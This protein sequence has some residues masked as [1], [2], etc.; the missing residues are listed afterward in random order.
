LSARV[1]SRLENVTYVNVEI[2]STI[3]NSDGVDITVTAISSGLFESVGTL[4]SVKI[5]A[6]I[7]EIGRR[8]FSW[9]WNLES[10]VFEEDS[11]LQVIRSDAF[12]GN[13][14]RNILIPAS[15]IRIEQ[16]AFSNMWELRSVEFE[17]GSQLSTLRSFSFA[18]NYNLESFT[19]PE[20][21]SRIE[22]G[23]LSGNRNIKEIKVA[24]GNA[25]YASLDG[26]LYNTNFTSLI[27]YPGGITQTGFTMPNS[28]T[29]IEQSAFRGAYNLQSIQFTTESALTFIGWDALSDTGLRNISLPSGLTRIEGYAFAWNQRLGAVSIPSTVNYVGWDAFTG[30]NPN[31]II[32]LEST[33]IPT[34]WDRG[35]N[36]NNLTVALGG[37]VEIIEDGDLSYMVSSGSAL[38]FGVAADNTS[39]DINIPE[40]IQF[41]GSNITVSSILSSAFENNQNLQSIT[42][43]KTIE[44]INAYAFRDSSLNQINFAP[45]SQL[46]LIGL[47]AFGRTQ[48]TE[49]QIPASVRY[50]RDFAFNSNYHLTQVGF[51]ADSQLVNLGR[52]AFAWNYRM[53]H[54][55]FPDSLQTI[56]SYA[57]NNT[58]IT[59]VAFGTD[60]QLK[61]LE[62]HAFAWSY[63]I[64]EVTLPASVELIQGSVFRGAS[65]IQSFTVDGNNT[66]YSSI[67]GVLYNHNQTQLIAYPNA[68]PQSSFE[69]PNTVTHIASDAFRNSWNLRM[70]TFE[71]N[72]Q[73]ID[74]GR[75]AFA[76]SGLR[77]IELPNTLE[78]IQDYAFMW[79]W[80]LNEVIIRRQVTDGVADNSLRIGYFA[81]RGINRNAVIRYEG[82]NIPTNLWNNQ[83]NPDRIFVILGQEEVFTEGDFRFAIN[84]DNEVTLLGFN[85]GASVSNVT[86]PDNTSKGSVVRI[87]SGAFEN[88]TISSVV[89][90]SS[91]IE[92][93]EAAFKNTF[94]LSSVTLNEGLTLIGSEAF[95]NSGL[96]NV[97]IPASVITIGSIA[98]DNNFNLSNVTFAPSSQ[99]NSIGEFAFAWNA[100]MRSY[101]LPQ[102]VTQIAENAFMGNISLVS[103]SF[104]GSNSHYSAEDGVL[105]NTDKTRLIQYPAGLTASSFTV[106]Q[107]VLSMASFAMRGSQLSTINLPSNLESIGDYVFIDNTALTKLVIPSSVTEV[108]IGIV[109]NSN[110]ALN[111]LDIT[112]ANI[113]QWDTNW[114]Q[115]N[116]LTPID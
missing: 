70:V 52:Y 26:V 1:L 57:F 114:N 15:V 54:F 31:M 18:W 9:S 62:S 100:K 72:S 102:S 3:K 46:R 5:P 59:Q 60:S 106:P 76:N 87:A 29:R 56:E 51:D 43:P 71:E 108:G 32:F 53:T 61:R 74:I 21:V 39:S 64:Q 93:D 41:E 17:E 98:F 86:I 47:E 58:E 11:Q 88:T 48:L 115:K 107:S 79:S 112:G 22:H 116:N 27:T 109:N 36:R 97:S 73:L 78:V 95:A 14:V 110:T 12:S 63:Q 8:A 34:S 90:P 84:L 92:I 77:S 75:D 66:H 101:Q 68:N 20:S 4:Q 33:F 23:A 105:Y 80:N 13:R 113:D 37:R 45:D 28:V 111:E 50:I 24:T 67:N 42:I 103:I 7:E 69:V 10:V 25:F 85:S 55:D 2:P 94:D 91:I 30:G 16:S 6:S 49:V 65:S 89:I 83:W 40:T 104:D 38:V 44:S 96:S 82:E 19:V 35:W 99:L 81:F